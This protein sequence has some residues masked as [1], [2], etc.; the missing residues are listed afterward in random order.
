MANSWHLATHNKNTLE[1]AGQQ[2]RNLLP[3]LIL[4]TLLVPGWALAQTPNEIPVHESLRLVSSVMRET[5]RINVYV[6]P[7][8]DR[9][10]SQRFPVLYMP[11]GGL[12]EDFPHVAATV[13]DLIEQREIPPVIVVGV[14]NT[15]RRRDTTPPTQTAADMK[16]TDQ[17]G[18]AERFRTFFARELIPVVSARY[19]VTDE[20]VIMGESLAGL[21]ILDT[22]LAQPDL[23][24]TYVALDPSVWWNSGAMGRDAPARLPLLAGK[25]TRLLLAAAG[26][27]TQATEVTSF[28]SALQSSA[29]ASLRW[30]YIPRVDLRHD[31]IYRSMEVPMLKAAFARLP[32]TISACK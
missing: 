11:D 4:A 21:F 3:W 24:D 18:G 23:F 2:M 7:Q 25:P 27:G 22:L 14:E 8:Y 20:S 12:A 5:R 1:T 13:S 31:N 28:V 15:V 19:R 16:V 30:T 32:A 6:P 26:A 29:P 9:C 10:T 17:P